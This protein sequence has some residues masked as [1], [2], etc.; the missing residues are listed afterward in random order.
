M[1]QQELDQ[2]Q[3]V[4]VMVAHDPVGEVTELVRR[5]VPQVLM[6]RVEVIP[7]PV[8]ELPDGDGIDGPVDLQDGLV[9]VF[10]SP[11]A[12]PLARV[13]QHPV[14]VQARERHPLDDAHAQ[15][16]VT[17][18]AAVRAVEADDEIGELALRGDV[19][20]HVRSPGGDLRA[21]LLFGVAA[22]GHITLHLPLM[23]QLIFRVEPHLQVEK[24][25]DPE[26][27]ETGAAP[28]R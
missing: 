2:R 14:Q 17:A 1:D 24:A 27:K 22:L 28:E 5:E 13:M 21:D 9:R 7:D 6:P 25:P 23:L 3:G 26:D 18:P 15:V 4:A 12:E 10:S 8:L 11:D 16:F 20:G 19:G